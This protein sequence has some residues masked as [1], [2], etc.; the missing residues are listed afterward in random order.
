MLLILNHGDGWMSMYG[1]NEALLHKVGDQVDAGSVLGTA[2]PPTGIN[3]GAYF[4]LRQN[5]KPVDPR[6]WLNTRR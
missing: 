3:T 4:E 5:N 2:S 6:R 1:N